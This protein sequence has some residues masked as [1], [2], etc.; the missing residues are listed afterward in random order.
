[1]E[2]T[3]GQKYNVRICC[4]GRPSRWA[5]AHISSFSNVPLRVKP[6]QAALLHDTVEDS[7][8]TEAELR[9]VFGN[10]IAGE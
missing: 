5:L 10:E 8:T 6:A 2:E 3:T 7:D 4:G 9:E 1:M